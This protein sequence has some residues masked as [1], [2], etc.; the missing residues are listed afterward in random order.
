MDVGW[1]TSNISWVVRPLDFFLFSGVS[2]ALPVLRK[3]SARYQN[4]VGK[5]RWVDPRRYPLRRTVEIQDR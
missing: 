3:I 4:R 5:F 1:C 2:K